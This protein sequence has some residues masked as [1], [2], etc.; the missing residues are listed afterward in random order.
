M[1]TELLFD[2]ASARRALNDFDF[3]TVAQTLGVSVTRIKNALLTTVM[4][5]I[6]RAAHT[7]SSR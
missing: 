6:V 3:D 7:S 4:T 1:I 2:V 5:R